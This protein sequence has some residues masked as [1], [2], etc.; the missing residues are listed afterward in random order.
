[1]SKP[2]E[3]QTGRAAIMITAVRLEST[4]AYDVVM[5]VG[6][7]WTFIAVHRSPPSHATSGA[8]CL[9]YRLEVSNYPSGSPCSP[10]RI[11]A[12][13]ARFGAQWWR[14]TSASM[15]P[16]RWQERKKSGWACD[17]KPTIEIRI[18]S[19]FGVIKSG[20]S[21]EGPTREIKSRVTFRVVWSAPLGKYLTRRIRPIYLRSEPYTVDWRAGTER[22]A[23][24][25]P[26]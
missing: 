3:P 16:S 17:V 25:R 18:T 14:D 21:I 22:S 1:M 12:S 4:V 9:A 13:G 10:L 15:A 24:R 11:G 5:S 19:P 6:A 26:I 8:T 2:V 7:R 23:I 20:R